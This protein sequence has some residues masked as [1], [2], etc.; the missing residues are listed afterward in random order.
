MA[1]LVVR[2]IVPAL[3]VF[4]AVAAQESTPKFEVVSIKRS[5][6]TA[7]SSV[8]SSGPGLFNRANISARTLIESAYDLLHFQVTGGPS[9][10]ATE[11]FNIEARMA[12]TTPER[13][14][15]MVQSL[16]EDRF[17]LKVRLE[18]REMRGLAL[19]Q[20]D[21]KQF[22]RLSKPSADCSEKVEMPTN[23]P[24]NTTRLSG[25]DD[26]AGIARMIARQLSVPVIDRT[27]LSGRFAFKMFYAPEGAAE[28]AVDPNAPT[29][30]TALQEQ[31]GL[32][33]EPIRLPVDILVIDSI[34]RPTEN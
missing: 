3:F 24:P 33:L 1:R 28:R 26:M 6:P 32:K 14:L 21:G 34:E 22:G 4:S 25:C 10:I 18:S 20:S 27:N 29:F 11:R 15:Q 8:P 17:Q 30:T 2:W 23:A 31:L 19:V 12:P 7:S 16:L 9:W 5:N 13:V